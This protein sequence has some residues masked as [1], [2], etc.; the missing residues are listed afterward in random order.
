MDHLLF[1]GDYL[2]S[3]AQVVWSKMASRHENSR[4]K[5]TR[6]EKWNG[7]AESNTCSQTKTS[8][9]GAF[10]TT[11][12]RTQPTSLSLEARLLNITFSVD[13]CVSRFRCRRDACL[14]SPSRVAV[15]QSGEGGLGLLK[16]PSLLLPDD[17]LVR[18]NGIFFE[19]AERYSE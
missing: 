10:Q 13:T 19:R 18:R 7:V 1:C 17:T 16:K 9:A 6:E 2:L 12:N 4:V 15:A 5:S 14:Y 3:R 11:F 8:S